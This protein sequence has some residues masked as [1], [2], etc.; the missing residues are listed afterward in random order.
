MEK[1]LKGAMI[2]CVA[3]I[4]YSIG[5]LVEMT[6]DGRAWAKEA[7]HSLELLREKQELEKQL[8]EKTESES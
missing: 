5:S 4:G 7:R 2:L 8:K 3:G 1:F 6:R